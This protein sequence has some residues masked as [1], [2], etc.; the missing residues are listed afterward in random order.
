MLQFAG[1]KDYDFQ[2]LQ[3][4]EAV[5]ER[6][7]LRLLDKLK[8]ALRLAEGQ[9]DRG[10]GPGV[11]AEDRRHARGAGGAADQRAARR[12]RRGAAPTIPRR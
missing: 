8:A 3:A 1:A 11:Q 12:R 5:N 10:L 4:V 9:A 7:K 6:Q 2:I